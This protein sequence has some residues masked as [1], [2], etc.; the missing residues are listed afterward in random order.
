MGIRNTTL[1]PCQVSSLYL[2]YLYGFS[3]FFKRTMG[4]WRHEKMIPGFSEISHKVDMLLSMRSGL[5]QYSRSAKFKPF[6][7]N[8]DHVST[9]YR[10]TN[11]ALSK[12]KRLFHTTNR[13]GINPIFALIFKAHGVKVLKGASIIFGRTFRKVYDKLP[14]HIR[15]QMQKHKII[16]TSMAVLTPAIGYYSYVHYDTCPITGRKRWITF[17]RDQVVA[18]SELDYEQLMVNFKGKFVEES[19][20]IFQKNQILVKQL[21]EG[22]TDIETVKNTTWTLHVIDDPEVTNAFVLPNGHIFVFTGMLKMLNT[23]EEMAVILGH[24]M[25][26]AILGHSQEQQ[27]YLAFGELLMVPLLAFIWFYFEDFLAF[28]VYSIQ[29]YVYPLLFEYGFNLPYG[30]K[31]EVEADEVGLLLAAKAC[32]D[33][34]WSVLLWEK[35]AMKEALEGNG[36]ADDFD[37]LSTHPSNQKRS[38]I[39]EEKLPEVLEIRRKCNCPPLPTNVNPEAV[40]HQMRR[41][42]ENI[43]ERTVLMEELDRAT[44]ILDQENFIRANK[45]D[46][47]EIKELEKL[48][49]DS[50]KIRNKLQK[51]EDEYNNL[52]NATQ[53]S[54]NEQDQKEE[55]HPGVLANIWYNLIGSIYTTGKLTDTLFEKENLKLST[56]NINK[57]ALKTTCTTS[58]GSLLD[59]DKSK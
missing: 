41:C 21:V 42:V 1:P 47:A 23:W 22:N 33:P 59:N 35:M 16:F 54:T 11:F 25:S 52:T 28:L 10:K 49:K 55:K 9:K 14:E 13:Q 37:F 44:S 2:L 58:N 8:R 29:Q 4:S 51:L 39:L 56:V 12:C 30:R 31:L 43:K 34:R 50:E 3:S 18:L 24:E 46:S 20:P 19:H 27:S 45:L 6:F 48:K 17:T 26:H 32:F 7:N 57:S 38:A 40:A 36:D 5:L 15:V 53:C